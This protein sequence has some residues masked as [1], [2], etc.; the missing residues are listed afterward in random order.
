[1]VSAKVRSTDMRRK[2][3]LYRLM[4]I[5]SRTLVRR[6]Q[7]AVRQI[8]DDVRR[9]VEETA[10][11]LFTYAPKQRERFSE[12]L[13]QLLLAELEVWL[14]RSDG[15]SLEAEHANRTEARS[16]PF[17]SAAPSNMS[18]GAWPRKQ[19]FVPTQLIH[20]IF[21]TWNLEMRDKATLLGL[22][23]SDQWLASEFLAGRVTIVGRDI[24]DR[25]AYLILI[26]STL[27]SLFRNEDVENEWL[28]ETHQL[29]G[30]RT[31]LSL[32]LDGSLENILLVK[33]FC[34][35]AGRV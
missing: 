10:S 24:K 3:Q 25:I 13:R 11:T 32:L 17:S 18:T 14:T 30:G 8:A 26:K 31:P 34:D 16:D 6:S 35:E 29:L 22:E 15:T 20:R 21:E 1:M 5:R 4:E 19:S 33:Q 27:F 28:R 9:Q 7:I 12:H 23:E 2:N